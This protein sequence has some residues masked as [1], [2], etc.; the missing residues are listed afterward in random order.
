MIAC[1]WVSTLFRNAAKD[2]HHGVYFADQPY[3]ELQ[4]L[5]VPLTEAIRS[6]L[7]GLGF[8]DFQTSMTSKQEF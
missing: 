5:G 8:T 6:E 7:E 2:W 3:S 4:V 1:G